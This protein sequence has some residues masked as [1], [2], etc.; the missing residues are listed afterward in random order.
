MDSIE[1]HQKD[2]MLGHEDEF[3]TTEL[4]PFI[5]AAIGFMLLH[6]VVDKFPLVGL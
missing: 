5:L 3:V 1:C 2:L 6:M 4:L